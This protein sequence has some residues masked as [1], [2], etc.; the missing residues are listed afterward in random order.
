MEVP[1]V[2]AMMETAA[3]RQKQKQKQMTNTSNGKY[4][5]GKIIRNNGQRNEKN[6]IYDTEQKTIKRLLT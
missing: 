3:K 4:K 2:T 5:N 6:G 1:R